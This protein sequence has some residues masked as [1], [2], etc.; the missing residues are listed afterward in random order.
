VNERVKAVRPRECSI[1]R[2]LELVGE[3]WALLALREVFLGVR[4]FDAIQRN[5]GAPRDVLSARLYKLLDAGILERR[6]YQERPTRLEYRLTDAGRDLLPV[7]L[8][9]MD[10]GDKYL[11][12]GEPPLTYR[13]SCGAEFE[14]QLVC[15]ACGEPV[16]RRDLTVPEPASGASS[17]PA[18]ATT[19]PKAPATA[20]G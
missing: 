17:E 7:L 8:T 2:T 12:D 9:L 20:A 15:K 10:W 5:T 4:R 19:V 1:A 18:P 6:Q 11:A 16:R 3:R 13:H 14:P